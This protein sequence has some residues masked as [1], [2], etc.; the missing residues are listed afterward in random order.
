MFQRNRGEIFKELLNVLDIADDIL[1]ALYDSNAADH[2]RTLCRVFKICRKEN[3]KLNKDKS[4]FRCK[5]VPFLAKLFPSK[6]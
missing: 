4:H 5:S 6:L 1:I 2:E 3:L